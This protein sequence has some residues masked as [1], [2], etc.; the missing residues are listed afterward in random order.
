MFLMN[1]AKMSEANDTSNI[2][3][4]INNNDPIEKEEE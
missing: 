2:I 4:V 1:R 3:G